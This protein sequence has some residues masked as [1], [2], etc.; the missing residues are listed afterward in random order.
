VVGLGLSPKYVLDDM[1]IYEVNSLLD[2]YYLK[3]KDSWEQAR[4]IAYMTAQVKSKNTLQP[5]DII[6][7]SWEKDDKTTTKSVGV[8]SREEQLLIEQDIKEFENILNKK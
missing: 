6:K 7:F 1:E 5:E 8:L 2:S 3:N 4:L